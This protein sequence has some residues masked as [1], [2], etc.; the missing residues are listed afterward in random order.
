VAGD[1]IEW[2]TLEPWREV[3]VEAAGLKT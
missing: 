1:F 2:K 3:R